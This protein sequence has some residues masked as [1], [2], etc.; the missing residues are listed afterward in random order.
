[1][2]NSLKH[3]TSR[4]LGN[5]AVGVTLVLVLDVLWGVFSR[6]ILGDQTRWTEELARFLLVWISFIGAALAFIEN[7]HLGVDLL[8]T[9]FDPAAR[10]AGRIATQLLIGLF[11]LF[12]L[13]IGGSQLVSSRFESGQLLPALQINKGWF[14]LAA[15]VSGFIIALFAFGDAVCLLL[16]GKMEE[17]ETGETS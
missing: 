13:G 8:T 11:A 5:I 7:K 1:M 14:Y 16:G 17:T 3:H 15:P 12:V 4:T 6:K 2:W 9:R 10:K